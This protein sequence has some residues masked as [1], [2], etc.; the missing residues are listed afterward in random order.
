MSPAVGWFVVSLLIVDT[1]IN[2]S[3][4]VRAI[5]VAYQSR[6]PRAQNMTVRTHRMKVQLR[7]TSDTEIEPDQLVHQLAE[8]FTQMAA[9]MESDDAIDDDETIK[10]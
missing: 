9:R 3:F 6:L 4:A 2:A 10:H 5:V 7:V 8:Y 1:V